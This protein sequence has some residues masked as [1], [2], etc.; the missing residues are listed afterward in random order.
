MP[1]H[2]R[3]IP[4]IEQLRQRATVRRIEARYGRDAT[5]QALRAEA[6]ALRERLAA[7]TIEVRDAAEA[8]ERIEAGLEAR[9]G[10]AL[11]PSLQP[12][13]NASGVIVHTNLGRAPLGPAAIAR[14]AA[15]AS[16][17]A[18]LEYDLP[19]GRR[20]SR[21]AHAS[22]LLTRLTG[23]ESAIVV[24][25]NAAAVLLALTALG[26]G[27]EVVISRG[28]LV[29]I[30]GGFRVPDVLRQSGAILREV[31]TTNR[32]RAADYATAIDDRTAMLLRVHPSNFRIEGFTE[33][34]ALAELVE[35][36]RRFDLPVV[37]DLGS[38]HLHELAGIEEPTV[39]SPSA[40][41]AATSC[42][43]ARRRASSPAAARSW[44]ACGPTP[45]MRAL[46]VDKL[47]YA[48]LEATLIE[49]ATGRAADTVPVVRMIETPVA[50]LEARAAALLTRLADLPGLT[51]SVAATEATIGGGSTPGLTLPS[52]GLAVEADG[53]SA[54][55][56]AA[57]LRSGVPPVVG[58]IAGD[59][60]LLDLRAVDPQSD[61]LLAAALRSAAR[62]RTVS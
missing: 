26:A 4:S 15:V 5:V 56:L 44:T 22:R 31:G 59:R 9:L 29:E 19:G 61:D 45:L 32:T 37:E 28:E 7:S 27:R 57:A 41:S 60:L 53:R 35:L 10:A 46:R 24:N 8:A 43:A 48:A 3:V 11:S 1:S 62:G 58:R 34:P 18:N 36:G 49:H 14:I 55:A 2:P 30:G 40:R 25:N 52:R 47:T 6:A 17:Y 54:T 23:A 20:G 21:T 33:R 51:V 39:A 42:S 12:V 38:G 50:D 13:I 16:G